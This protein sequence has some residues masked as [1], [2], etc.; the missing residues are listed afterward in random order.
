MNKSDPRELWEHVLSQVELSISPANFN[1]W[2]R[3][4]SIVKIED[5]IVYIGVPSQFFRDWY[6]K[7]FHPL[8]L[9]II[10]G[11]SYEFRNIEY[12]IVKDA[13]RKPREQKRREPSIEMP[14]DEF[15]INKSDN[16][17]PKYTFETFVIGSFNELAS[18]AAQALLNRPCI[19]KNPLFIYGDTGLG[20]THR[21]Q[22]IGDH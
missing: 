5:G 3:E 7:K 17:N 16:L 1:T 18:S 15:Y 19:I 20:K 6:L 2:F 13:S 12:M 11:V 8:L 9:K 10:R 14:L 4:S 22:S 21:I